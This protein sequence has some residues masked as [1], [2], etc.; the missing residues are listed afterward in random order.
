MPKTS[1]DSASRDAPPSHLAEAK[2]DD[3]QGHS[4]SEDR[5]TPTSERVIKETSVKRREAMK[6]L[7]N[8]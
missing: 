8:R 5:V 4:N 3:A 2:R 6:V 7:A 1:K